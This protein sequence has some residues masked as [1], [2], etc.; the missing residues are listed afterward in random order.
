L[1]TGTLAAIFVFWYGWLET[2]TILKTNSGIYNGWTGISSGFLFG[3]WVPFL[4][5]KS[6]NWRNKQ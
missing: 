6:K 2:G 3:T 1:I 4:F 5:L